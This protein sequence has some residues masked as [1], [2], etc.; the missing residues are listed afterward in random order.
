MVVDLSIAGAFG[1]GAAFALE[2]GYILA[3]ALSYAFAHSSAKEPPIL[4]GAQLFDAIRSPYYR[5]MYAHLAAQKQ[6]APGPDVPA[7]ERLRRRVAGFG[8]V[9]KG[10]DTMAW[11]YGNDIARVWDDAVEKL[12]AAAA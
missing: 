5:R 6:A 11:I 2:D 3:R 10:A 1:S 8:E 7:E 9:G 4:A 12:A